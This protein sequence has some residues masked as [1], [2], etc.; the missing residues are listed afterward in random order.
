MLIVIIVCAVYAYRSFAPKK[1]GSGKNAKDR[2]KFS[3]DKQ[4]PAFS[5]LTEDDDNDTPDHYSVGE[6]DHV[7]SFAHGKK[8]RLEQ[9]ETLKRAGLLEEQEYRKKKQEILKEQ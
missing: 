1:S 7:T 3:W 8:S 4:L 9:L 6:H 5:F 2:V